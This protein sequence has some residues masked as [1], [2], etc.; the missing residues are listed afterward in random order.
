MK[1]NQHTAIRRDKP[2]RPLKFLRD[3]TLYL[4][5]YAR[6]LDWGCGKG[7]DVEWLLANG[8]TALGWDPATLD[9]NP[10]HQREKFDV[11]MSIYVLCVIDKKS[12]R[13]DTIQAMWDRVASGGCM[14]IAVR[15]VPD[16]DK[17][18][19]DKDWKPYKDGW[20]TG[21]NTFQ[22]GYTEDEL[23]KQVLNLVHVAYAETGGAREFVSVRVVKR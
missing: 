13:N 6:V 8:Y 17:A 16:I 9:D 14:Y 20:L 3:K 1:V 2:S 21:R 19:K 10:P 7:D 15:S 23:L 11:V 22:K 18:K 4:P 5:E 12:V